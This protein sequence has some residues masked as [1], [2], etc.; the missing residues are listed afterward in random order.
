[1]DELNWRVYEKEIYNNL[2]LFK[3]IMAILVIA[4]HTQPFEKCQQPRSQTP[5]VAL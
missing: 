3:W 1:M 2:D 5:Q 4:I